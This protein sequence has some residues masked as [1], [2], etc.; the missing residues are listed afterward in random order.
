MTT[1][2]DDM[3]AR[4]ARATLKA[5]YYDCEPEMYGNDVDAF[6]AGIDSDLVR[7][8]EYEA[9]A[10][11]EAMQPAI[12]AAEKRG[13]ERERERC[14]KVVDEFAADYREQEAKHK[15]NREQRWLAYL[16][17]LLAFSIAA[18]IR[19]GSD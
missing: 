4:V 9:K 1:I 2:P 7:D 14:A 17:G 12:L 10:A 5:R 6:F 15:D 11:I 19:K 8:A 18:A 16:H 3:V 13:E